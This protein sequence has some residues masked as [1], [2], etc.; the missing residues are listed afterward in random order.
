MKPVLRVKYGL[1][2]NKVAIVTGATGTLGRV[3][4]KVLLENGAKVVASYRAEDKMAELVE[5]VGDFKSKLTGVK[6]DV[7][8]E[9][10]VR[11]LVEHTVQKHERIDILL[12]VTGAYAG[13]NDVASTDLSVWDFMMN[14]N[15]KSAFLCCKAVL[16][17]MIRQNFGRIVNVSSSTAVINSRR[18]KSGAYAVSK[19]GVKV[20]T[21]TIA[22]EIRKYDINANCIIPSTIDT[23][24]NRRNMPK[25]DFS[26]CVQPKD[27]ADVILFLVSDKSKIISGASVPVYG[28]AL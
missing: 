24:D 20:L 3:V 27:I 15:L 14:V 8:N 10:N 25:A 13:G 18:V 28:K 21:E 16:P 17:F 19:A 11:D 26:K 5:F 7:T 2:E 4:A 9:E 23:P 12:N 1:L 22:E 6:A